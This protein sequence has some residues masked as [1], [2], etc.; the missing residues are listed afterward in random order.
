MFKKLFTICA[1]LIF[2]ANSYATSPDK[3]TGEIVLH[4][5]QMDGSI[6]AKVNK[7]FERSSLLKKH[8]ILVNTSDSYII[9]S[10]T[11]DNHK[12][13]EQAVILVMTMPEAEG[14]NV[15]NLAVKNSDAPLNDLFITAQI[16]AVLLKKHFFP[17]QDSSTWPVSIKTKNAIVYVSGHLSSNAK[18]KA[19]MELIGGVD[20]AQSIVSSV[21]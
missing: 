10:G 2:V 19:L 20:G 3:A 13:Y 14:L 16:K 15:D 21:S 11:V 12:Q 7:A 18:R 8:H 4:N 9:L 17:R 1:T 6:T 5:E